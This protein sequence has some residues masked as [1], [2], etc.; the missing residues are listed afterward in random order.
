MPL[1]AIERNRLFFNAE[2]APG[3]FATRPMKHRAT[4]GDKFL[5]SGFQ[6]RI[7]AQIVKRIMWDDKMFVIRQSA[8]GK[9]GVA[10]LER[11]RQ[12]GPVGIVR[13]RPSP[14]PITLR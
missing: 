12:A 6:R 10:W 14:T 3:E 7:V 11:R 1:N 4:A 13:P 8:S 9:V 5:D 2:C